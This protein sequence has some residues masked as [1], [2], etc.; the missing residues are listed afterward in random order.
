M[1]EDLEDFSLLG[2]DAKKILRKVLPEEL[3]S[4]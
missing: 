1:R 4:I 2:E 3:V